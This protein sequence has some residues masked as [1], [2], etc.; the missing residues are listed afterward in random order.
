MGES[1]AVHGYLF[2]A[3]NGSVVSYSCRGQSVFAEQVE[4]TSSRCENDGRWSPDPTD[5]QCVGKNS[6][7]DIL[8]FVLAIP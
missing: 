5:L 6:S 3:R 2:P 7:H 4:A 8:A 1:V